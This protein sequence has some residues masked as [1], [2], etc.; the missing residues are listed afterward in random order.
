[1]VLFCNGAKSLISYTM[2]CQQA[3]ILHEGDIHQFSLYIYFKIVIICIIEY[4]GVSTWNWEF[5]NII[6]NNFKKNIKWTSYNLTFH[7][8]TSQRVWVAITDPSMKQ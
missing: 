1:M 6:L 7:S 2:M 5:S 4:A 8:Q 3:H